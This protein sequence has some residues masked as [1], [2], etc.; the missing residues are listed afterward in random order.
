MS[1]PSSMRAV[2]RATIV[3]PI[4]VGSLVLYGWMSDIEVLKRIVPGLVAMNPMTAIGFLL[5][6]ISFALLSDEVAEVLKKTGIKPSNVMLE[7]TES[8]AMEGAETTIEILTKLKSLGVSLA[9]DDF[10]TGFSSLA[11]LKRFPVDLLKIDK[12]FVDG[13][14]LKGPDNAIVEAIIALGHALVLKVIAEG[15]ETTEQVEQLRL[16][17]SELGQGFY[18]SEPLASMHVILSRKDGEGSPGRDPS[19]SLRSGSG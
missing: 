3:I 18:Y 12:S 8:V 4:V 5:L 17:G 2:A 9:I 6:G 10:G 19:P 11:Y 13:V 1:I 7:I 14:A 16:L 15:V